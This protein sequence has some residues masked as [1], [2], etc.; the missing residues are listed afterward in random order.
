[1][2]LRLFGGQEHKKVRKCPACEGKIAVEATFCPSC[3]LVIRPEGTADLRAHLRGARIPTDVY[4]LRKM[5]AEDPNAGPVVRVAPEAPAAPPAPRPAAAA[6]AAASAKI[7][8]LSTPV[9]LANDPAPATAGTHPPAPPSPA[10]ASPAPRGT[11]DDLPKR[12]VWTGVHTLVRF[13]TPLPPPAQ[14]VEDIPTLYQWM[15][16]RDPLIPNNLELLEGIHA[17]VFPN[18]PAAIL[19]YEQHILLLIFDDLT[20]HPTRETLGNHLVLLTAA[21]RRAAGAYHATAEKGQIEASVALWQMSSTASRLRM[22][23]WIYHTRHGGPPEII[24]PRRPRG[25]KA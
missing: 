17:R 24:R 21:Y 8:P 14:T 20:L 10:G 3:F 2:A 18:G 6:S 5:Q 23:A 13:E 4:L 11:T 25:P 15:L 19:K 16:A 7:P 12:P 22:E 1:M 9:D